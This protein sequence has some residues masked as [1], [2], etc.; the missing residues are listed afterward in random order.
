[1]AHHS[2]YEWL[3]LGIFLVAVS[4]FADDPPAG[5]VVID[6]SDKAAIDQHM[7]RHVIVTG[8]IQR[9]AWSRS[10]KVL[11]IEFKNTQE[12]KLIAVIFERKRKEFDEAF[13]G[14]V[15]KAL[16]GAKVRLEGTI[17]PY[18][19]REEAKKGWPQIILDQITQ[20]TI[21]EPPPATQPS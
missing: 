6:A 15:A 7:N 11:N 13:G 4:G 3:V 18:G 8:E 17:K 20:I 12:S 10:G 2:P 19:G 14:D 21:V 5:H 1:M 9:A 16:S